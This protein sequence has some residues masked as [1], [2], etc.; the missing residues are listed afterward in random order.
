MGRNVGGEEHHQGEEELVGLRED[1]EAQVGQIGHSTGGDETPG[2]WQVVQGRVEARGWVQRE[3]TERQDYRGSRQPPAQRDPPE[4]R[5]HFLRQLAPDAE[6]QEM[7]KGGGKKHGYG[8]QEPGETEKQ[9]Q[10]GDRR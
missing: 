2:E 6:P 1:G 9:P 4:E 10:M 5:C 3:E 8:L 7:D